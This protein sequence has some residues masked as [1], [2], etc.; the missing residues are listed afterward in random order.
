MYFDPPLIEAR[1]LKRYKRFLADITLSDGN[2]RVTTVHCPNTG[3]MKNCQPPH[4]KIWCSVSDNPKRKYPITWELVEIPAIDINHEP[5]S[6]NKRHITKNH[7]VGINT[8]RANQLVAEAF[9]K[10]IIKEL[11]EYRTVLQEI[12]YGKSSRIDFLLKNEDKP[13]C[14][15]EVKSVTLSFDND[16]GL[17]PDAVTQ[18][19]TR[20]LKELMD[21]VSQGFRAV[22]LFCVQH[23]GVNCVKPAKSIDPVY[24]ETLKEAVMHGVEVLAYSA[25][26]SPTEM[27]LKN[28]LP[29]DISP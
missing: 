18:R 5:D 22:L 28:K 24:A 6:Y 23:T 27:I 9:K 11:Q 1:L 12:K 4:A 10:N 13:D 7:I 19:G 3:S 29:V 26:L 21:M 25:A 2:N 14:Y 15:V 20:H 17:F 16:T 8:H